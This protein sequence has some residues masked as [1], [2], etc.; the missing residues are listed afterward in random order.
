M[1]V[2]IAEKLP[3]KIRSQLETYMSISCIH[4]I[5]S[6]HVSVNC[7]Y[8]AAA[9]QDKCM[10]HAQLREASLLRRVASLEAYL[11]FMAGPVC[12]HAKHCTATDTG[13][14]VRHGLHSEEATRYSVVCHDMC[15][16]CPCC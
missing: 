8:V 6:E 3:V 4:A 13:P 15:I 16:L 2:I 1:L 7:V 14:C 12:H 5:L 9:A 11:A 10:K